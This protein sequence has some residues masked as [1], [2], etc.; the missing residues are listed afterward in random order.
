M[1]V[2]QEAGADSLSIEG[3]SALVKENPVFLVADRDMSVR[4]WMTDIINAMGYTNVRSTSS[5]TMAWT[6]LKQH[7]ADVIISGLNLKDISGLNLLKI[8]RADDK[9]FETPF[10][11]MAE[12]VT[13]EQVVEAGEAAVT[14]ILCRP[15]TADRM[16]ERIQQ[17]LSPPEDMDR[18]QI[19]S[20]YKTGTDMM[21]AERWEEALKVFRRLLKVFKSS[22]IYY[23]M[24]YINTA[25]GRHDQA[26]ICFR[27]AAEIDRA[28]DK[29]Y[30]RIAEC[31]RSL[32]NEEEAR[33][34]YA[35]AAA[36]LDE[37]E[38]QED[39]RE[40]ILREVIKANPDTVNVYNTM[41]ILHRRRGNLVD[42]LRW[43]GKALKVNPEDE[44][45]HYN[46]GRCHFEAGQYGEAVV[47]LDEALK[48]APRFVDARRL[49]DAAVKKAAEG[50]GPP[51]DPGAGQAD[52][53]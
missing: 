17:I 23:N 21:I 14:E 41:G 24:G 47:N 40:E 42:A 46:I 15:I 49:R 51:V 4:R 6:M 27:K 36:V 53:I 12:L 10:L 19:E 16:R 28:L 43:Y 2:R 3:D 18:K 48:L 33:R 52:L 20:L 29:A 11:L 30:Q 1:G 22:E 8:A 37:K 34:Y 25:L 9:Y 35:L 13:Q 45:I 38:G 44:N 50:A 5:G 31:Y 32:G 26:I 39:Q 7:G